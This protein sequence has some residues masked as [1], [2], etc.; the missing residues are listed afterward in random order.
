MIVLVTGGAGSLGRHVCS[1]L[2]ERGHTVRCMDINEAALASM[3]PDEFSESVFTPIYGDI[4]D[5]T[6][7][8][9]AM[10][11]CHAVIHTAAMK[12]LDVTEKNVPEI[13][14]TNIT[15]TEN[16]MEAAIQQGVKVAVMMG[17]D[18]SVDTNSA[19]GVS[20]SASEW[21]W[22]HG[23]RISKDTQFFVVRSGNFWVSAGNV[24]EVWDKLYAEGKP[25][26]LTDR[27]MMRWFIKTE[28]VAELLIDS[29][30]FGKTGDIIIPFMKEYP[31]LDLLYA[32]YPNA[33]VDIIGL[34]PGEQ[35]RHTLINPDEEQV[36]LD[37]GRYAIYRKVKK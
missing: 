2:I 6:R 31:M 20:K 33:K 10:R 26:K 8:N 27:S 14:R 13:N 24:F 4:R 15:G 36:E 29:L 7:V 17:T 5:F 18:K 21:L 9:F 11:G 12:N 28:D 3:H 22:Y 16:V 19:Y 35:L 37:E 34:R 23:G 25:L 32:R 30:E 1:Q